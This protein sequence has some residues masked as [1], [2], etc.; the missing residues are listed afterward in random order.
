MEELEKEF[1]TAVETCEKAIAE[2]VKQASAIL[3]EAC[4]LAEKHGVPFYANVS[5]ISQSYTPVTFGEKFGS[6]NKDVVDE[7][8]G[9]FPD[10]YSCGWQHSGVCY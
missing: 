9:V 4:E 5:H 8:C 10:E 1:R 6:L 3:D 7:L 2:K